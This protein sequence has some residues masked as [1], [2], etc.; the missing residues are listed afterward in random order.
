M[1]CLACNSERVRRS[2]RKGTLEHILSWLSVYPYR[3]LACWGR[4]G[5][6]TWYKQRR[7]DYKE[8]R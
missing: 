1:N 2:R 8:G 3:C 5:K 7:V 6:F 4:F